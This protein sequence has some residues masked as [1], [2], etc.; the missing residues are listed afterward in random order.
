MSSNP[1][2]PERGQGKGRSR[3]RDGSVS[4]DF[5]DAA[6]SQAADD[7]QQLI[8][9]IEGNLDNDVPEKEASEQASGGPDSGAAGQTTQSASLAGAQ[10]PGNSDGGEGDPNQYIGDDP[11]GHT[12]NR[13]V[14]QNRELVDE[15]ADEIAD[16]ATFMSSLSESDREQIRS[17]GENGLTPDAPDHVNIEAAETVESVALSNDVQS[18]ASDSSMWLAETDDGTKMYVTL[19]NSSVMGQPMENGQI[20]NSFQNALSDD[21]QEDLNIPDVN[22]D[23][24]R[25]GVVVEDVGAAD[26]ASVTNFTGSTDDADFTKEGYAKAVAS[27]LVLGDGDIRE[28]I[29]TSSDGEF[30]PIDYDLAGSS[31]SKR[32]QKARDR[33]DKSIWEKAAAQTATHRFDFDIQPEDIRQEAEDIASAVDTGRLEEELE[34]SAHIKDRP[35]DNVLENVSA[36]K[37]GEI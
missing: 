28:N 32:D 15:V 23:E 22:V 19:R 20:V 12:L 4:E 1:T 9:E 2:D 18:G 37:N 24:K 31:L 35:A 7:A 14:L 33:H 5:E 16:E 25:E 11:H 13:R 30:H 3:D 29:V 26:S 27:K 36:L 10:T 6:D 8:D 17:L 34:S 21:V